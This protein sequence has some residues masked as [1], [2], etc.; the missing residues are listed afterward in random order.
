YVD[1]VIL[2]GKNSEINFSAIKSVLS[3]FEVKDKLL[4]KRKLNFSKSILGNIN[5]D[6]E[7]TIEKTRILTCKIDKLYLSWFVNSK[8]ASAWKILL[9]KNENQIVMMEQ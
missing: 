9:D 3:C 8:R 7:Q 5:I 4:Q 2:L 6:V 1:D